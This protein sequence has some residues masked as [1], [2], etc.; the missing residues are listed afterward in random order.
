MTQVTTDTF[1]TEVLQSPVPVIVDFYADHCGPCR[2][3]KPMLS[4]LAAEVEGR[5]KIVA[6]DAVA[7]ET[8]SQEFAVD[9]VPTLIVFKGGVPVARLVGSQSKQQLRAALGL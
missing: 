5:G 8:L 6:V 9:V 2:A 3:I 4:E 7:E 1:A